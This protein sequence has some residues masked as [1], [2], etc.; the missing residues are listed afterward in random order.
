MARLMEDSRGS[1]GIASE[2][3]IHGPGSGAAAVAAS[4]ITPSPC[5]TRRFGSRR[6]FIGDTA[7]ELMAEASALAGPERD[8]GCESR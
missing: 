7:T 4:G 3:R 5:A 1:M 2:P 6:I 8:G